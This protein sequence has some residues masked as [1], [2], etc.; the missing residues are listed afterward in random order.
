MSSNQLKQKRGI[1]TVIG[2]DKIGTVATISNFLAKNEINIEEISQT[3]LEDIFTMTMLVDLSRS[4]LNI[5]ELSEQLE[6]VGKKIN[7]EI[8]VHDEKIFDA[9]HR[10]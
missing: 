1:I 8:H 7:H 9:M 6:K 3:I 10:I 5:A 4:N 2:K